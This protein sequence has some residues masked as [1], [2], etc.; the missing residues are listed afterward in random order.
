MLRGLMCMGWITFQPCARGTLVNS[1]HVGT[2]GHDQSPHNSGTGLFGLRKIQHILIT[3]TRTALSYFRFWFCPFFINNA[4][5]ARVVDF[6]DLEL[7]KS[8]SLS[9]AG[10]LHFCYLRSWRH[11]CCDVYGGLMHW[12]WVLS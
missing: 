9:K 10:G 6:L 8:S 3:A 5:I 2:C 12:S 1:G 11:M 7:D 4:I